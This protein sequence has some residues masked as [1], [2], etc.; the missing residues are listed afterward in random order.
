M[1]DFWVALGEGLWKKKDS[2]IPSEGTPEEWSNAIAVL[3]HILDRLLV[4]AIPEYDHG[5]DY[6][7]NVIYI[8][9]GQPQDQSRIFKLLDL[10]TLTR[11]VEHSVQLINLVSRSHEHLPVK[12]ETLVVPLI[13]RLKT[14]LLQHD[15]MDLPILD[16]FLRALVGRYLQDLLGGP[17][18]QPE[19]LAKKVDCICDDCAKVNRFLQSDAVTDTFRVSQ[20]RR[21]HIQNQLRSALQ[22]DVTST[23]IG[24]GSQYALRVTKNLETLG[25]GNWN[26]RV[27]KANGF[28]AIVGTPDELAR[29]MGDQYPDF[30]AALAGTK[31][32]EM[33]TLALTIPPPGGATTA[34]TSTTGITTDGIQAGTMM[35]GVKRKAEDEDDAVSVTSD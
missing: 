16:A 10:M 3:N 4:A 32:Y 5:V 19:A 9:V 29:I 7:P 31:P 27:Q 11:R 2:L 33:G 1:F 22:G 24:Q 13:P 23:T 15:A 20:R 26:A 30:Q 28:L 21:S 34:T 17:S 14:R 25:A 12:Y 18:K 6:R 8:S 35:A